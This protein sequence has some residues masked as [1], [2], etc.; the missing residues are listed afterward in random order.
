MFMLGTENVV[1]G[2]GLWL[3]MP[4]CFY[5]LYLNFL[6]YSEHFNLFFFVK[7]LDLVNYNTHFW[8][9]LFSK[10][11]GCILVKNSCLIFRPPGYQ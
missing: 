6:N 7:K 1:G 3:S 8:V 5:C 2:M 4:S 9:G 11:F 10:T